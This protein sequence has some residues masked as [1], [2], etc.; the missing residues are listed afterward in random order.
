[1]GLSQVEFGKRLGVGQ[2]AVGNWE[3]GKRI[4]DTVIIIQILE[5]VPVT[6]DWILTGSTAGMTHSFIQ[7]FFGQTS[8]N[9]NAPALK[10]I[11]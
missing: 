11:N 5:M 1:M 6:S 4:P 7:E 9:L 10:S 3:T 8:L 2:G